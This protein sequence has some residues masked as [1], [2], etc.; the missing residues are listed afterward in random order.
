M[1]PARRGNVL[2][3]IIILV[4]TSLNSFSQ[5]SILVDSY[6]LC[7]GETTTACIETPE[8]YSSINWSVYNGLEGNILG[9][10]NESCCEVSAGFY[11]LTVIDNDNSV[12]Y[13]PFVVDA[14]NISLPLTST[15][16]CDDLSGVEF[17]LGCNS[18]EAATAFLI[19]SDPATWSP[20]AYLEISIVP[21]DQSIPTDTIISVF[22]NLI[23]IFM[24]LQ[25]G[26]VITL[27]YND[28]MG[29]PTICL[30]DFPSCDAP[31]IFQI[32]GSG[33]S[34]TVPESCTCIPNN[35]CWEMS[36]PPG[37]N[38]SND[39][40]TT[41]VF[42]PGGPGEYT[43]T[44]SPE[45]CYSSYQTV[46]NFESTPIIE[47]LPGDDIVLCP[48]MTFPELLS[49]DDPNNSAN[50]DWSGEGVSE[51]AEENLLTIG[52]YPNE[53]ISTTLNVSISNICGT[54]SD[55]MSIINEIIP[56]NPTLTLEGNNLNITPPCN[57][58]YTWFLDGL[59]IAVNDLPSL[60]ISSPGTY[61]VMV[62]SYCGG[63][64]SNQVVVVDVLSQETGVFSCYPN[65]FHDMVH[66]TFSER[67]LMLSIKDACG[68]E[69][70][71]NANIDR[72]SQFDLTRLVAG[73]YFATIH[74]LN[75]SYTIPLIR[76]P[77]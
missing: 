50:V 22:S 56:D 32:D 9:P 39:C 53:F 4:V 55:A 1:E 17:D 16:I 2:L 65:P 10:D 35:G 44:C 76:L 48:G 5:L 58:T 49:I 47:I 64:I 25:P 19:Y 30:L 29:N 8:N 40:G 70:F 46:I 12:Y 11:M 42:T 14:V 57:C 72:M 33:I 24:N 59:P 69:V 60:E 66:F 52:P 77:D 26:D 45:I 31:E 36:G 62:E 61:S 34:F 7:P 3:P 38:F 71:H 51:G 74:F 18:P 41:T 28:S 27:E 75:K 20:G 13:E 68:T 67:V 6:Q 23:S 54:T 15:L 37:G 43:L 63:D 21:Q 73:T